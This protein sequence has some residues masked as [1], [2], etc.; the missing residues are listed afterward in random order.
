ML[1]KMERLEKVFNYY[2]DLNPLSAYNPRYIFDP[3]PYSHKS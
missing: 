2:I 1:L 3:D